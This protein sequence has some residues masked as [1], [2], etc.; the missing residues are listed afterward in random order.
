M[1]ETP[2]TYF[3]WVWR[4]LAWAGGWHWSAISFQDG[5]R[6]RR[7]FLCLY[8]C[9][10]QPNRGGRVM[11]DCVMWCT[12]CG[13]R[14][15]RKESGEGLNCCPRC[16]SNGVPCDPAND[17]T[18]EVNWHEL[19]I[20]GIWASNWA[21]KVCDG[22]AERTVRSILSRLERQYPEQ[23]PLTLGG[24]LRQVRQAGYK[25]ES[26]T[27]PPEGFVVVNGPGAVGHSKPPTDSGE[28][29]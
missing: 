7:I 18:V 23:N 13:A 21:A 14:I 20:L 10:D 16:K 15:T 12:D 29:G 2:H 25:I 4:R 28:D 9:T 19:R 22:D 11:D 24:E 1:G 26:S 27:I 6:W 3:D 17:L 8:W 5:S